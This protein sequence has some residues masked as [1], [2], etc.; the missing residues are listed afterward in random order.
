MMDRI[1]LPPAVE[2]WTVRGRSWWDERAPRERL[3]LSGLLAVLVLAIAVQGVWRPV[4]DARRAARQEIR[5]YD[6]LATRLR[7]AGPNLKPAT[8]A[9]RTGSLPAVLTTTAG[10]SALAIR[11]I[12][13]QGAVTVIALDGVNFN[14]LIAWLDRLQREQGVSVSRAELERQTAPGVVNARLSMVRS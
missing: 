14:A 1:T 13:Q 11:Q 7:A 4:S 12:E 9:P 10:E 3:L 5:I 2:V 6:D 8:G